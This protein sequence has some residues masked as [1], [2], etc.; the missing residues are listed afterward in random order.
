MSIKMT[1]VVRG[2]LLAVL[3][4]T[5][6]ARAQ[7]P[8]AALMALPRDLVPAET[9]AT[10]PPGTFLENLVFTRE[11]SLWI[12]SYF[13]RELLRF[14]PEQGVR[15]LTRLDGYPVALEA[16]ADGAWFMTVHG[17]TF[18]DGRDQLVASQQ[19]WKLDAQGRAAP[20]VA[21][22]QAQF[23]NGMARLAPG[24]FLI[25]DSLA[26]AIWKF[27]VASRQVT[28]W[29]QH[30]ALESVAPQ[31]MRPGANGIRV[32]KGEVLVSNS[33]QRTLLAIP[34][35][36]DGR[37]GEPRVRVS[38]VPIDDF[39]VAE[40]GTIFATTHRDQVVRI[41]PDGTKHVIAEHP[42]VKGNTSAVFGFRPDDRD[43]LYV[44]GDGGMFFG[45]K[46]PAG[47]VRLK[48]GVRGAQ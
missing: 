28:P 32:V 43:S 3:V 44:I 8:D 19:I 46:F 24:V 23:L 11:G 42:E 17:K 45:G 27:D 15:L 9:L 29:L 7:A 33:T 1:R 14:D 20:Y 47:L 40:D 21:V 48:V 4:G 12:T 5:G 34:V 41:R 38:D 25:T 18:R 39:A 2:L 35:G 26:G 22:P 36:A 37:P 10:A 13:A 16:D 6:A 31:Q 30:A